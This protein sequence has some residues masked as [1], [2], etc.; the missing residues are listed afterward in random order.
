MLVKTIFLIVAF[1]EENVPYLWPIS[2]CI[3]RGLPCSFILSILAILIFF[4]SALIS[5]RSYPVYLHEKGKPIPLKLRFYQ[6]VLFIIAA[7]LGFGVFLEGNDFYFIIITIIC[8]VNYNLEKPYHATYYY[9]RKYTKRVRIVNNFIFLFS[10]ILI[11]FSL[12]LSHTF[13]LFPTVIGFISG[14][15]YFLYTLLF[16]T[17]EDLV[18]FVPDDEDSPNSSNSIED[19]GELAV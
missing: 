15:F 13:W 12:A 2:I 4:F 5:H 11:S 1:L 6:A 8:I 10:M 19:D 14:L 16:C 3:E 18:D 17:I 7:L 9:S